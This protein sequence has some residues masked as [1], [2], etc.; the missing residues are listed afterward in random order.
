LTETLGFSSPVSAPED[1]F[2]TTGSRETLLARPHFPADLG[3]DDC[4]VAGNCALL[5]SLA[6][7]LFRIATLVAR[8]PGGI[9]V[10]RVDGIETGMEEAIEE[11]IEN[12]E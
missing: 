7:D 5:Q 10:R 8:H 11:G 4:L 2:G 1:I 9:N 12:I 3:N 6:N